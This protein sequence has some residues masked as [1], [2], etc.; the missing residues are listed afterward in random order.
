MHIQI[1]LLYRCILNNLVRGCNTPYCSLRLPDYRYH[2]VLRLLQER[3]FVM[4]G[5]RYVH[6]TYHYRN[7]ILLRYSVS[8]NKNMYNVSPYTQCTR[9]FMMCV[10]IL[11]RQEEVCTT[12]T[13]SKRLQHDTHVMLVINVVRCGFF[14]ITEYNL[15]RKGTYIKMYTTFM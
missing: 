8:Y 10:N 4:H 12:Y 5:F 13:T 6:I 11:R 14:V 7:I 1:T 2:N 3:Y 9:A 15:P